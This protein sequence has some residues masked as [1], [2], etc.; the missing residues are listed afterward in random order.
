MLVFH[1]S[2]IDSNANYIR[3]F[4]AEIDFDMV[5]AHSL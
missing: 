5:S 3:P 1:I 4:K 2:T